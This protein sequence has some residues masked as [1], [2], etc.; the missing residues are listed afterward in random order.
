MK[1]LPSTHAHKRIDAILCCYE[2]QVVYT[3]LVFSQSEGSGKYSG[4]LLCK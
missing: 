3:L 2:L 4:K 1:K